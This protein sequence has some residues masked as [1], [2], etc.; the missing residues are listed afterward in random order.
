MHGCVEYR[1]VFLRGIWKGVRLGTV[2]RNRRK[3]RAS[4][5]P[6]PCA[7][8][9]RPKPHVLPYALHTSMDIAGYGVLL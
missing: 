6:R 4:Y 2:G 1:T 8:G 9:P 7:I 5:G 3:S